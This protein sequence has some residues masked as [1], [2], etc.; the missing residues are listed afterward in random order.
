[1]DTG[2]CG[3]RWGREAELQC[4]RGG[5]AGQL[6]PRR[7]VVDC[8]GEGV[9]GGG[10]PEKRKRGEARKGEAKPKALLGVRL[11]FPVDRTVQSME[12]SSQD[13]GV[14]SPS[15]LQG[16]FLTQGSNP[17]LPH[18][19]WILYQLS[20]QGSPHLNQEPPCLS[21]PD[22]PVWEEIGMLTEVRAGR[23]NTR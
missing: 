11:F 12:F 14:G 10:G 2:V 5:G 15:L 16:I 1:M 18:C 21:L 13:T 9:G 17:G 23:M 20:H 8:P 22:S 3:Q 7:C 19:N 6:E 4:A